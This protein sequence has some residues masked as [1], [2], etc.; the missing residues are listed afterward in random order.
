M[1][2]AIR[3]MSV[4]Q[5]GLLALKKLRSTGEQKILVERV[6]VHSG[7]QAIVGNVTKG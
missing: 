2:L 4:Y 5:D 3:A 6:D 1:N 7:A